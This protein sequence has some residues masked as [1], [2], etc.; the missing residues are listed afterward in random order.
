MVGAQ[1]GAEKLLSGSTAEGRRGAER[2]KSL[3]LSPQS[4]TLRR[5]K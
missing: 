5:V 2:R 4:M 3:G 1:P